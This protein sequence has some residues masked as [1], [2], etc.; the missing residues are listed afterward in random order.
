MKCDSGSK[1]GHIGDSATGPCIHVALVRLSDKTGLISSTASLTWT[2]LGV[3][4]AITF[5]FV[6]SAHFCTEDAPTRS[7]VIPCMFPP[8][9]QKKKRKKN[10]GA[11][12][13]RI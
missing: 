5:P 13:L 7:R 1:W 4:P 11:L 2:F 9:Y 10:G 6:K 8:S 12:K 3:N